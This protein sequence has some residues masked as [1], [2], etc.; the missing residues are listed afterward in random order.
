MHLCST[1]EPQICVKLIIIFQLDI[2]IANYFFYNVPRKNKKEQLHIQMADKY[3]L[4]KRIT[5]ILIYAVIA[6]T[7]SNVC[8]INNCYYLKQLV[9]ILFQILYTS[10]SASN[11]SIK[12]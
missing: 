10:S 7:V 12:I 11:C 4:A 3:L 5:K 6:V 2:V 9:I 8:Y 1:K